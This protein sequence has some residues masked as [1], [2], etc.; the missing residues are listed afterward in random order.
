MR[1][2]IRKPDQRYGVINCK[3]DKTPEVIQ[4]SQGPV[5]F[6]RD[7]VSVKNDEQMREVCEQYPHYIRPVSGERPTA[8]GSRFVFTMPDLSHIFRKSNRMARQEREDEDREKGSPGVR[9]PVQETE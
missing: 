6:D 8:P 9:G 1:A 7:L 5:R 3:R 2:K 4:T